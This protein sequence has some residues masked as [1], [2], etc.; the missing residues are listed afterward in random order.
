MHLL[1]SLAY[2]IYQY[3]LK[4]KMHFKSQNLP[5]AESSRPA[6]LSRAQARSP[7]HSRVLASP[8]PSPAPRCARTR[9]RL[10]PVAPLPRRA[11]VRF[12]VGPPAT[13]PSSSPTFFSTTPRATVSGELHQR[14]S[15]RSRFPACVRTIS[16]PVTASIPTIP[17][18][19]AAGYA[20]SRKTAAT[21]SP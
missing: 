10:C 11:F 12:Q 4:R 2:L 21:T 16:T 5:R 1:F 20:S 3:F 13:A 15:N 14:A 8:R 17:L 19:P 6:L 7:A 9:L 18:V